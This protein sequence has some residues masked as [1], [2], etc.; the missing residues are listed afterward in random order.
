MERNYFSANTVVRKIDLSLNENEL[1]TAIDEHMVSDGLIYK[2]VSVL[3]IDE[4]TAHIVLVPDTDKIM[5][6]FI[7]VGED[8]GPEVFHN[9]PNGNFIIMSI[10]EYALL[11]QQ[12]TFLICD[13]TFEI[14]DFEICYN[15]QGE[16]HAEVYIQKVSE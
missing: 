10:T 2:L 8:G 1:H 15:S 16:R 14:N 4:H 7:D 6:K 3:P 5:V 11:K 9:S 12:E 13:E